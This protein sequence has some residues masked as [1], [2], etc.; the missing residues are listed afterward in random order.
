MTFSAINPSSSINISGDILTVEY[1]GT[2]WISPCNG[3]Q[4]ATEDTALRTEVARYLADCQGEAVEPGDVDLDIYDMSKKYEL[5]TCPA[6][7]DQH[8]DSEGHTDGPREYH[9]DC[10]HELSGNLM[11]YNTAEYI[12]PATVLEAQTSVLAGYV[13][14]FLVADRT[15]YVEI[16]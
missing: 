10:W 11:D 2:M 8:Q 3:Q 7:G 16:D 5:L 9:A 1:D 14:A 4:H 15:C 13:G 6:C 12:R